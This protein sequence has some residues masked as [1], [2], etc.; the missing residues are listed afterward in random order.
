MIDLLIYGYCIK[1]A[2]VFFEMVADFGAWLPFFGSTVLE[3]DAWLLC[4]QT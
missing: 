4:L 1:C 2:V 3:A